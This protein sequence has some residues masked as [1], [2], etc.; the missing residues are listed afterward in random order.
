METYEKMG[1]FYLGKEYDPSQGKRRED[2]LLLKSKD[3]LTHGVCVG[4]TGSGKT[5]LCIDIIEE[6]AIDGVSAIL[7]DMKGDIANLMLTFADLGAD[8]FLPYIDRAAAEAAGMTVEEFAAKEAKKW[9]DGLAEW[10]QDGERIRRLRETV[11]LALFTPKSNKAEPLSLLKSMSCPD[12]ELFKEREIVRERIHATVSGLLSLLG[13]AADPFQSKPYILLAKI[14]ESTWYKGEDLDL[15][16]M[17]KAIQRPDF[18]AIGTFTLEDFYPKNERIKLAMQFNNLLASFDYES[19]M[20]GTPLDI[21]TLL[22]T[23]QGKPKVSII[24]LAHLDHKDKSFFLT[25]LLSELLGYLRLQKGSQVL[26]ALLYIDE[27]YGLFPPVEN[28]PTK[29][30]LMLLLKQ[31]RAYGLGVL[32]STQ[33]PKDLDYRGLANIGTWFIGKLHTQRDRD[34]I[35]NVLEGMGQ[36]GAIGGQKTQDVIAQLKSRLFLLY[37]VHRS[38]PVIFES[39]WALSYLKGPL[40]LA[41]IAGLHGQRPAAPA[42][43]PTP[44]E[45]KPVEAEPELPSRPVLPAGIAEYF[46]EIDQAEPLQAEVQYAPTTLFHAKVYVVDKKT[47]VSHEETLSYGLDMD[48]LVPFANLKAMRKLPVAADRLS[49][50]FDEH[51]GFSPLPAEARKKSTYNDWERLFKN[52]LY[53]NYRLKLYAYP[54]LDMVSEPEEELQAFNIRAYQHFLQ[55]RDTHV[56]ELTEKYQ[57]RLERLNDTILRAQQRLEKEKAQATSHK[58]S[59]A[60]SFGSTIFSA[61]LGRKKVSTSTLGR[62]ATTMKSYSR[63]SKEKTDVEAAKE[64]LERAQEKLKHM[65]DKF[66]KEKEALLARLNPSDKQPKT[67]TLKPRKTDIMVLLCALL[68]APYYVAPDG[69]RQPASTLAGK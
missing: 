63:I 42:V 17:I 47:G 49:R 7:I 58:I 9:R 16:G 35:S 25:M 41:Q 11:E 28:P 24:Y 60:I 15:A 20:T 6:A 3:L 62:A 33:N 44:A 68:W 13:I 34:H 48:S 61:L 12:K 56:G 65:E 45:P 36:G 37:S 54:E 19:W 66:N 23:P 50:D 69:N 8:S 57:R 67:M 40:T 21:N 2:M 64:K 59:T 27:L 1:L 29:R 51:A 52:W 18:S 10:D 46:L 30:P 22:Y 5:G 32:L 39:R 55:E 26:K 53:H 4:M 38:A 31:A 14:V 43:G